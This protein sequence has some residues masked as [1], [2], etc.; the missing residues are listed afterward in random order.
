MR[1]GVLSSIELGILINFAIP[2][3]VKANT[4]N[5]IRANNKG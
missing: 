5:K 3:Y 4:I 2:L 1:L